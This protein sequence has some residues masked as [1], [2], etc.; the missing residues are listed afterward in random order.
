LV[1][2]Y[3]EEI[4]FMSCASNGQNKGTSIGVNYCWVY[5]IIIFALH[6]LILN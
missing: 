6:L 3:D 1:K 5:L 4:G 2:T